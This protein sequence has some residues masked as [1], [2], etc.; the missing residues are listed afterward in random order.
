MLTTEFRVNGDSPLLQQP[1]RD[2]AT[3]FAA[4]WRSQSPGWT[5]IVSLERQLQQ[6]A[7]EE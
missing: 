3:V 4:V 2:I 6:R 5:S 7:D 1:F